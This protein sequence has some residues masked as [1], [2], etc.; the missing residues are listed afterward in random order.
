MLRIA[1]VL[2]ATLAALAWAADPI[3]NALLPWY[4]LQIGL[5]GPEYRVLLLAN[6]KKPADTVVALTVNLQRPVL[7][8]GRLRM[9][10]P[11]AQAEA[12]TLAWAPLQSIG[13]VVATL[14]AWPAQ[15]IAEHLWRWLAGLPLLAVLIGFDVP[16][17]LIGAVRDIYDPGNLPAAWAGLMARGGRLALAL[18]VAVA[19]IAL[20]AR[21][22]RP[23]GLPAAAAML[24]GALLATATPEV[25]A[26]VA[27]AAP[28]SPAARVDPNTT[29]SPWAGVGSVRVNGGVFSGALIGR[30]YVLTAAHVVAGAAATSIRFNLNFGGALTH[31]IAAVARYVYPDYNGFSGSNPNNDIAIIELQ[32]EVPASVPIY[33]LQRSPLASGSVLRLVGY[34]ASGSGDSGVTVAASASVKRVGRNRADQ[35]RADDQGSGSQE[36]YYFD[37]DGG[38]AANYMGGTTLGNSVEATLAGGDSGA[39]AFVASGGWKLAGVN[40]F[41][42]AFENGPTTAGVFGSAGGGQSVAAYAAWIDAT[43]AGAEQKYAPS[44]DIPTLPQWG[45]LLLCMLLLGELRRDAAAPE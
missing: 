29:T 11:R 17:T 8:Q 13:I 32:E 21:I 36:V 24:A 18:S 35:F 5:L 15:R 14:L 44:E 37:F 22:C 43:I 39:P 1:V 38:S 33:A 34:G 40:T 42:G 28:D 25:R 10:D 2:V 12:S 26:I 19:A 4:R 30:R 20:A 45:M 6:Q 9:P 16:V 7:A 27:G 3:T 41:V 31:D 23:L